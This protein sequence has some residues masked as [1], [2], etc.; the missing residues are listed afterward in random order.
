MQALLLVRSQKLS[1]RPALLEIHPRL[2]CALLSHC[3]GNFN[4]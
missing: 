1:Q 3:A 4:R 2:I